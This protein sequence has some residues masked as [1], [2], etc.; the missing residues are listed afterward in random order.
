MR[1]G[2]LALIKKCVQGF[3]QG[4]GCNTTMGSVSLLEAYRFIGWTVLCDA[5]PDVASVPRVLVCSRA[6]ETEGGWALWVL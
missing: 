1:L 3:L 2:V 5:K 4:W 6:I